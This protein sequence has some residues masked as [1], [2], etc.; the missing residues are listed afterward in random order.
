MKWLLGYTALTIIVLG[1]TEASSNSAKFANLLI[2]S[3]TGGAVLARWDDFK[4]EL[5]KLGVSA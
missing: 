3:I 4:T 5:E 1:L 2:W